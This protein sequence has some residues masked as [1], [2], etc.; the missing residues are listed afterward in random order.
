MTDI[1]IVLTD[2][3]GVLTDSTLTFGKN[4]LSR[5]FNSRDVAGFFFLQDAN[6]TTGVISSSDTYGFENIKNFCKYAGTTAYICLNGTNKLEVVA[7]ILKSYNY[8][9]GNLAYIG[10]DLND[11]SI[12][13]EAAYGFCPCDAVPEAKHYADYVIFSRGGNGAFREVAIKILE[14]CDYSINWDKQYTKSCTPLNP[15]SLPS[16]FNP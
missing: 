10:D 15:R 11:I 16:H 1:K 8:T 14:I 3:D 4:T 7:G 12:L 13:R 6:I 5:N 2:C 9:F